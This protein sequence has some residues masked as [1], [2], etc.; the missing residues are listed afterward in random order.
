MVFSDQQK[1]QCVL[2]YAKLENCWAVRREYRLK[3]GEGR[4]PPSKQLIAYWVKQFRETGSLAHRPRTG[5]P[6]L[7]PGKI[8]D[9]R[10][11]YERSPKTS[12]RR[13]SLQ[14]Q[15]SHTTVH[16]VLRKRL[17][18]FPYKLQLLHELKPTDKPKRFDWSSDMLDQLD[19]DEGFLNRF[20]VSDEATFFVSGH[21]NRYNCRIWARENPHEF[22][23]HRR[24]T[25]KVNVWCALSYNEVKGI[26]FFNEKTVCQGNYLDM[27]ENYAMPIITDGEGHATAIFQQDGAPPHYATIVRDYLDETLPGRWCGRGGGEGWRAWPPR[28][29]DLTPLD[30]FL[31]GYVKD[32]VYQVRINDLAHL[33]TRITNAINS[34]TPEMLGRVWQEWEYRL[35]ICRA[36]N[37]SHIEL[38]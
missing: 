17:N 30:F 25:A 3:Y 8:E 4:Q 27:L 6:P 1:A 28:S 16:N 5:R 23:E 26:F 9:I 22:I 19:G 11:K 7:A 10:Q 29:P 13:A 14:L 33:K 2:W 31:W 34:V 35:D 24:G 15:V 18:F 36:T 20:V 32:L 21:V 38:H 12:T 37:G